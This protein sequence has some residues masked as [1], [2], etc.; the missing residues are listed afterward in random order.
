MAAG[1]VGGVVGLVAIGL[2]LALILGGDTT[3]ASS[4]TPTGTPSTSRGK[5]TQ[6]GTV[7]LQS[8]LPKKVACG[9]KRPAAADKPKPQFDH[10][11]TPKQVLDTGATYTA[12]MKTSCGTVSI[13]LDTKD[14]PQTVASFVFLARQ[15]YF[16]GTPFHRID[17][18][19]SVIQGG[20]PTGTGQ[21]GPGYSIPDELTGTKSYTP[22]TLAMA[23]S[24]Q[25]N[26]GGSQFFL[27]YGSNGTKLDAT[28]TYAVFGHVSAGLDALKRIAQI[29]IQDPSAGLS[30][31]MPS[32]AVFIDSVKI[33]EQKPPP[34][35]ATPT[36]GVSAT[37]SPKPSG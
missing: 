11:P 36:T 4:P 33:K 13:D 19:I 18:S 16:D 30:G 23:N 17:S 32:Q 25:P 8:Q 26:T 7:S 21:G 20:D 3:T 22:G 35:S 12:V 27:I 2:G 37:V 10:A 5:P 14:A 9:A 34:S 28:P 29:P 1:I 6:T 31:Q 24:G 15:H